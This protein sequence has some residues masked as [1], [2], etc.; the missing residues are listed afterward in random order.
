MSSAITGP[1]D[2][3]I[4]AHLNAVTDKVNENVPLV[5]EAL[6]LE[7]LGAEYQDGNPIFQHKIALLSKTY[8]FHRVRGDGNCF[9]RAFAYGLF[10]QLNEQS[11]QKLKARLTE[12]ASG[13]TIEK[14]VWEDFLETTKEVIDAPDILSAMN[15]AEQSNSVVVFLRFLTSNYLKAHAENYLPYLDESESLDAWC[16]RWV[17]PMGAEADHLQINALVNAIKIDVV[18]VNLDLTT[19]TQEVNTHHVQP[20]SGDSIHTVKLL[21]R[22]GHYDVLI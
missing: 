12:A 14:L 6:P 5:S 10:R 1:S 8:G 22:P 3:E 15:D 17:D 16:E 21:F 9:Y 19:S 20:D 18:I 2:A 13:M 4:L 7:K 11:L